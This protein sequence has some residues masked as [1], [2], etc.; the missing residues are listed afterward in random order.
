MIMEPCQN[1]EATIPRGIGISTPEGTQMT[2]VTN[3]CPICG[4]QTPW[5][6]EYK[7]E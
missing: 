6:E 1:C 5:G 3:Y 7:D 4:E 2:V